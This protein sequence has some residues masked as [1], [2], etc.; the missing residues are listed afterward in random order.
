MKLNY[1]QDINENN[2]P[3]LKR[4]S[5]TQLQEDNEIQYYKKT[6]VLLKEKQIIILEVLLVVFIGIMLAFSFKNFLL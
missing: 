3:L 5:S 4:F 6:K 1:D 2:I